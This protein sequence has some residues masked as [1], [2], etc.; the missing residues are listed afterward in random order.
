[1]LDALFKWQPG[2]IRQLPV[3]LPKDLIRPITHKVDSEYGH[4]E[5]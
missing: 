4:C 2:V 3:T 5:C 1:M